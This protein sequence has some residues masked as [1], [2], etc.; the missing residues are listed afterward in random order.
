MVEFSPQSRMA[1]IAKDRG[2]S[3]PPARPRHEV[4]LRFNEEF[5]TKSE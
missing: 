2:K 4:Q 3:N 1:C 5:E